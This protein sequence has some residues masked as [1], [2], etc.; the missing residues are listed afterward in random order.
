[1]FRQIAR[2][3]SQSEETGICFTNAPNNYLPFRVNTVLKLIFGS[4]PKEWKLANVVPIHKKGSKDDI[5]NYKPISIT[6]LVMKLFERI[7]KEELLLRTSD[8]ID[9]RQHGFLNLKSCSTNSFTDNVVLSVND[10]HTLST[11]VVY[12]DFSKAF[13]SVNDDLIL[14]KLKNSYSIDGRLL[15]FLRTISANVHKV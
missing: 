11:D 9:S 14:D 15:K 13:D 1:M 6:C 12:F 2:Q 10:T 8:L 3:R 5:K 7:L 4:L